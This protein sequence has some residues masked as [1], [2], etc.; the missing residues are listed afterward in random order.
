MEEI[1][2]EPQETA[3][4]QQ[5]AEVTGKIKKK[6]KIAWLVVGITAAVLVAGCAAV[7]GVAATSDT[8]LRGTSVL[9]LDMSGLTREE[10][11]TLWESESRRVLANTRIPLLMEGEELGAAS[12]TGL[13]VTVSPQQA[14]DAAWRQAMAAP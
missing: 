8:M 4:A 3:A 10:A 2:K 5:S 13:G 14:A 1:R 6:G 7:C 12:L 11:Q 9:G